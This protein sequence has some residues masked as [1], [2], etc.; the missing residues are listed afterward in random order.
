MNSL[1]NAL[2]SPVVWNLHCMEECMY[3][4]ILSASSCH[5]SPSARGAFFFQA[6]KRTYKLSLRPKSLRARS[7]KVT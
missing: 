2:I 4:F 1:N 5:A 3:C 7:N 6:A